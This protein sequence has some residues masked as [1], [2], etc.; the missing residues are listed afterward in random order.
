MKRL[1]VSLFALALSS[2]AYAE[3]KPNI[4]LLFADNL[5]YGELGN[6]EKSGEVDGQKPVIVVECVLRE[7]FCQEGPGIVD[8]GVDPS[9][10]RQ[11]LGDRPFGGATLTDIP[12]YGNDVRIA[13]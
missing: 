7:R 9:E 13:V 4:V 8:Q 2:G 6:V 1:C 5:G 3:S 11:P 12:L 10:S